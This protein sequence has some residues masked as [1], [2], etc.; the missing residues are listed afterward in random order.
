[1][2]ESVHMHECACTC[3]SACVRVEE[4]A[5]VWL[6]RSSEEEVLIIH[7]NEA[8]KASSG[9]DE[10]FTHVGQSTHETPMGISRHVYRRSPPLAAPLPSLPPLAAHL[11]VPVRSGPAKGTFPSVRAFSKAFTDLESTAPFLTH[12]L[13]SKQNFNTA[14]LSVGFILI[15]GGCTS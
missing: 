7:P 8:L 3:V 5:C 6:Q 14:R 11:T 12:L 2:H 4:G 10:F 9:E 13:R 15:S 1:M